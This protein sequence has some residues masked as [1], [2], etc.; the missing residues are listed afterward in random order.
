MLLVLHC[1]VSS[2]SFEGKCINKLD[3]YVFIVRSDI[4]VILTQLFAGIPMQ[5]RGSYAFGQRGSHL[6][7]LAPLWRTNTC[8]SWAPVCFGCIT[9]TPDHDQGDSECSG[10]DMSNVRLSFTSNHIIYKHWTRKICSQFMYFFV[11]SSFSVSLVLVGW[12]PFT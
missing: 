1:H 5:H 4:F 11:T 12:N 6:A 8:S 7:S 3:N 9:S 2:T 10:R